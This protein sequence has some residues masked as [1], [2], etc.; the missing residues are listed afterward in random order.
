M[1][2]IISSNEQNSNTLKSLLSTSVRVALVCITTRG[3]MPSL[4]ASRE[5]Y[6][7]G[8]LYMS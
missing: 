8:I 2:F 1:L 6:S 4:Y 5:G 3:F 7:Y